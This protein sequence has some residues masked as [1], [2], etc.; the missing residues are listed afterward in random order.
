MPGMVPEG[1]KG[2][3]DSPK[4]KLNRQQ[5]EHGKMVIW[6][7]A[8]VRKASAVRIKARKLS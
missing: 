2:H 8:L 4:D 6:L 5:E 3:L 7:S 1:S